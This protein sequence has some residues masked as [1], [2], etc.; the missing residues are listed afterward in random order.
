MAVAKVQTVKY[1][2]GIQTHYNI[3]EYI[4]IGKNMC[5]FYSPQLLM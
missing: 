3:N 5:R 4:P 2:N 1:I